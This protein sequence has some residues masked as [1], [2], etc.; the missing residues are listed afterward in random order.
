MVAISPD[1]PCPCESGKLFRDC[2]GPSVIRPAPKPT[3]EHVTLTPIPRP[4]HNTRTVFEY[5]GAGTT[6]MQGF[7][8]GIS[9]DC[10]NC[11]APLLHGMAVGQ[12]KG[13]VIRCHGC[14]TYNDTGG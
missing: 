13:I 6:V 10:G 9:F 11:G 8:T 4:P 3:T 7:Q 1:E 5:T 12:V 14:G 2:H